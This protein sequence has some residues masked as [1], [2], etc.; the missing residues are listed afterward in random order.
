VSAADIA[1]FEPGARQESPPPSSASIPPSAPAIPGSRDALATSILSGGSV[2]VTE[3]G[4][5]SVGY[6]TGA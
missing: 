2:Q 3:D 1:Q 4:Q 5:Y 6:A